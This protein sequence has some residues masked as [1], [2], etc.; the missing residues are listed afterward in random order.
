[1]TMDSSIASA[2]GGSSSDASG[3][4]QGGT[5]PLWLE[6]A[7]EHKAV[8]GRHAALSAPRASIDNR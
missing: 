2:P 8:A 1:M 4:C 3:R 6:L 5:D 7:L